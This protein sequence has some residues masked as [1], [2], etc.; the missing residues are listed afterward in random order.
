MK[1]VLKHIELIENFVEGKLSENERQDF[2]TRLIVDGDFKEEF[3]LYNFHFIC[4]SSTKSFDH[5]LFDLNFL[6]EFS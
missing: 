6:R 5:Q 1:E 4:R 2:E 3:D